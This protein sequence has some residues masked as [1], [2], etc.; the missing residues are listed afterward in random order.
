MLYNKASSLVHSSNQ[1][2]VHHIFRSNTNG[3]TPSECWIK[4]INLV[5]KLLSTCRFVKKSIETII[6]WLQTSCNWAIDIRKILNWSE[7]TWNWSNIS[8]Y[9][10]IKLILLCLTPIIPWDQKLVVSC[11]GT[12]WEEKY[13]FSNF[14]FWT[15][16]LHISQAFRQHQAHQLSTPYE[17]MVNFCSK[18]V[19]TSFFLYFLKSSYMWSCG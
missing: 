17:S 16:E 10:F 2:I 19:V 1:A 15:S 18:W 13:F 3:T 12:L 9:L 11:L 8:V 7:C 14:F 4:V 5:K 6:R